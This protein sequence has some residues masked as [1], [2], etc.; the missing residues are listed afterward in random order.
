LEELERGLRRVQDA[1]S[2][3][4]G[5]TAA[6]G[7][8]AALLNVLAPLTTT[9]SYGRVSAGGAVE[10]R[11]TFDQRVLGSAAAAWALEDLER[12]LCGEVLAELQNAATE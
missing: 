10:V 2:G 1:P 4:F 3:T 7:P 8:G 11:L 5:V 12:T 6:S 9:L